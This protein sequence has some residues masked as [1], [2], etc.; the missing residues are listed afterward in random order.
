MNPIQ[1]VWEIIKLR[2]QYWLDNIYLR[3]IVGP[4]KRPDPIDI[5]VAFSHFAKS[6]GGELSDDLYPN[7]AVRA[8]NADFI[9]REDNVVA[10]L[11][12]LEVNPLDL[13]RADLIV[14]LL[15]KAGL[16]GSEIIQWSFGKAPMPPDGVRILQTYFKKLIEKIARKANKQIASTKATESLPNAFGVLLIANDNNYLFNPLHK[17]DLISDVMARHLNSSEIKAVAFFSPNVPMI[18]PGSLREWLVWIPAYAPNPPQQLVDFIDRLGHE[19]GRY[20][21]EGE[22]GPHIKIPDVPLGRHILGRGQNLT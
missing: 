13:K 5:P 7:V 15:T 4:S 16:N 10:E 11:K 22:T 9:F 14:R 18:V 21:M 1:R 17:Y 20:M 12:C 3:F 19:W 8:S 6:F 2:V